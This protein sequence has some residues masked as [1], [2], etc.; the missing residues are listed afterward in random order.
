MITAFEVIRNIYDVILLPMLLGECGTSLASLLRC[1]VHLKRNVS[2]GKQIQALYH[3]NH[4]GG[5]IMKKIGYPTV[6]VQYVEASNETIEATKKGIEGA[7]SDIAGRINGRP[8]IAVVDWGKSNWYLYG[9][10]Y[11]LRG[12]NYVAF[13]P[14]AD[15][16]QLTEAQINELLQKGNCDV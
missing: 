2:D 6:K 1:E 4:S 12:V 16:K 14:D 7:L 15:I 13:T 11:I 8:S 10:P 3:I 5:N 9:H